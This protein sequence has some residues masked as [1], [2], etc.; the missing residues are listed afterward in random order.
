MSIFYYEPT[1]DID[2]FGK[3]R[4][5]CDTKMISLKIYVNRVDIRKIIEGCAAQ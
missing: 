4:Q 2:S 5:T 3:E 1:V